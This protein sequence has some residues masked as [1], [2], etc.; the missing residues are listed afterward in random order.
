MCSSGQ[1]LKR[2]RKARDLSQEAFSDISSCT[3]MSALERDLKSPTISKL[4]S[5]CEVTDVNSLTLLTLA[6]AGHNPTKTDQLL[7]QVRQSLEL[8]EKTDNQ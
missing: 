8:L 5:L 2:V 1:A 3:Y 6:Y 7:A 4:T